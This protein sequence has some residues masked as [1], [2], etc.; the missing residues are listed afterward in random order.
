MEIEGY[1]TLQRSDISED[2]KS[3]YGTICLSTIDNS[4]YPKSFLN[5]GNGSHVQLQIINFSSFTV[6]YGYASPKASFCDYKKVILT[7]FQEHQLNGSTTIVMGD[8]NQNLNTFAGMKLV[9][10]MK[11]L[12]MSSKLPVICSTTRSGT[13][14]D[15]IFTGI[16]ETEAYV[17]TVSTV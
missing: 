1:K 15:C 12:G 9:K 14:I 4:E 7:I 8:F 6:V 3:G 11:S 16:Q 5:N 2:K 13:Q 17:S 10:L